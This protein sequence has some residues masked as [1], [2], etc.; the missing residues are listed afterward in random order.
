MVE[1]NCVFQ[2]MDGADAHCLH[3]LG[4]TCDAGGAVQLLAYT[5][6]VPAGLTFAEAS[7]GRVVTAPRTRA[8]AAS[9]TR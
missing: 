3:L 4:E 6:L 2:D 1:Q 9:A 7:I 8:A 5:R